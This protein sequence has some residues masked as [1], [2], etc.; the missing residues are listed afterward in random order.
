MTLTDS[1]HDFPFFFM[2]RHNATMSYMLHF[3]TF[4]VPVSSQIL[5]CLIQI[6]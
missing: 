2:S 3:M 1:V 6:K 5:N 4:R